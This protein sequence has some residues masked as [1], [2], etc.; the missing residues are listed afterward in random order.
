[1]VNGAC[2][3]YV[4]ASGRE[5]AVLDPVLPP[6]EYV[7][8][9]RDKNWTL[10][11]VLETHVHGDHA[12]TA[13]ALAQA[14]WA[15]LVTPETTRLRFPRSTVRDG[16]EVPLGREAFRV[17]RAPGHTPEAIAF[18]AGDRLFVGDALSGV[19]ESDP[20]E[21]P[22]RVATLHGTMERLL[23]LPGDPLVHPGHEAPLPLSALRARWGPLL[24]SRAAFVE[25]AVRGARRG[26]AR[27]LAF[28]ALG[29]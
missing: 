9:V 29:L 14:A 13:R 10:T 19:V 20:A 5:A 2:H 1:M 23:A 15:R 26:D 21:A 3:S 28:N 11:L 18:H 7:R 6:H 22:M 16:D 27:V 12:S 25:A 24:S 4:L 17:L 8:V